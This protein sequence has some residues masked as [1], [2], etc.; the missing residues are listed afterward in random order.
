MQ[1]IEAQCGAIFCGIIAQKRNQLLTKRATIVHRQMC[2]AATQLINPARH[3]LCS[4]HAM[5][6][7]IM[8]ES[9]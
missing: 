9:Y 2:L 8:L 1:V 6:T 4:I 7:I 5:E 3:Q